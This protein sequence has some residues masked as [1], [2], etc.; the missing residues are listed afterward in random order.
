MTPRRGPSI[1]ALDDAVL[2]KVRAAPRASR[3]RIVGLHDDAVKI[4]VSAAPEKG[5]ANDAIV[6]VLARALR[7]PRSRVSL[8]SGATSRDKWLRV[9]GIAEEALLAR[10]GELS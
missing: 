1:R 8:E 4:A 7:L 9:E 5:K 6:R 10:L 2:L 3:D